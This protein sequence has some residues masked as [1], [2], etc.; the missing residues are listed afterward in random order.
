VRDLLADE[1]IAAGHVQRMLSCDETQVNESTRLIGDQNRAA[2]TRQTDRL[3]I[4]AATG[5]VLMQPV[6]TVR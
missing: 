2:N 1:G 3:L 4:N 5:E 6:G